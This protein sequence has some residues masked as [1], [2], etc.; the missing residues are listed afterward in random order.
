VSQQ[1]SLKMLPSLFDGVI[2]HLTRSYEIAY[3][4]MCFIRY[5]HRSQ[6]AG[7]MQPCQANGIAAVGLDPVAWAFRNER[8]SDNL[9]VM[10]EPNDLA[11]EPVSGRTSL[12]A[13]VE[14]RS[15]LRQL[16]HHRR[17]GCRLG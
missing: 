7:S 5:P 14:R 11:I 16:C 10:A 2:S 9:A 13:E 8:W 17:Y 6:F 3:R 15:S 4:L 1:K 12:V